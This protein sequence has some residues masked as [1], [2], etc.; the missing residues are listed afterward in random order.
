MLRRPR[1]K[2]DELPS[3]SAGRKRKVSFAPNR[4]EIEPELRKLDQDNLSLADRIVR[5]SKKSLSDPSGSAYYVTHNRGK[6]KT[7][8][9]NKMADELAGKQTRARLSEFP[10]REVSSEVADS[11]VIDS[12][13]E[14]EVVELDSNTEA[15]MPK[16]ES[17]TT[18]KLVRQAVKLDATAAQIA[19]HFANEY[20]LTSDERRQV[21]RHVRTARMSQRSLAKKIRRMRGKFTR[22]RWQEEV[23]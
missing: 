3:L 2:S 18:S 1:D 5:R 4:E 9:R 12:A 6:E 13:E 23:H 15:S 8:A 20:S 10:P 11:E 19:D 21:I 14:I 17:V 7:R 16:F 22:G